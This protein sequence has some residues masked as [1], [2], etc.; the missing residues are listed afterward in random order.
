VDTNHEKDI[1]KIL[2]KILLTAQITID[3]RSFAG[4]INLWLDGSS[5]ISANS[6]FNDAFAIEQ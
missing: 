4:V 5:S 3:P 2:A 1:V 6:I